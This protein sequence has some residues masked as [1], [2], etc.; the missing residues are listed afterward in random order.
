[1]TEIWKDKSPKIWFL[2]EQF[3]YSGCGTS[4]ACRPEW[5]AVY[6][7]IQVSEEELRDMEYRIRLLEDLG[8][9][10][11]LKDFGSGDMLLELTENEYEAFI[12]KH[13]LKN[14][15]RLLNEIYCEGVWF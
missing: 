15:N 6:V 14:V 3:S 5:R 13:Q 9:T 11:A 10:K 12:I 7:G 4:Q 1:M 8:G 2:M